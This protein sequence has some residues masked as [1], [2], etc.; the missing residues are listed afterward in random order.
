[1]TENQFKCLIFVAGLHSPSDADVRTRLLSRIDQNPD[2]TLQELTNECQRLMNLKADTSLVESHASDNTIFVHAVKQPKHPVSQ[3]T[4]ERVSSGIVKPP[5]ECWFCG[6]W[7]FA[8]NCPYRNHK[9]TR[10]QRFGHKEGFCRKRPPKVQ[11]NQPRRPNTYSAAVTFKAA[12]LAKR[13]FINVTINSHT[14]RLQ[15]DTASDITIISRPIWKCAIGKPHIQ[16]TND[17]IKTA[18]G[19]KMKL[20]GYP[21]ML[22]CYHQCSLQFGE[23]KA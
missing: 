11:C 23:T 17:V 8:R 5:T 4:N 6:S 10:C 22:S 2:I 13:K 18:S 3:S 7:H 20:A 15:L 14:V 16:P 9:C 21:K 1:M 12:C 19:E